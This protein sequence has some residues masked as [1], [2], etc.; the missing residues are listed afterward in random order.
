MT[1]TETLL[2]QKDA[3][4]AGK[5]Q[6]VKTGMRELVKIQLEG[7]LI[8]Q[9]A[10]KD[11]L[12]EELE[13]RGLIEEFVKRILNTM[14]EKDEKTKESSQAVDN[15]NIKLMSEMWEQAA[16]RFSSSSVN[17]F[18]AQGLK[19]AQSWLSKKFTTQGSKEHFTNSD[20]Y[21]FYES[22]LQLLFAVHAQL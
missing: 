11:T 17:K 4:V 6:E 14:K 7:H 20:L 21:K 3:E 5:L 1:Q 22:Q 16:E 8:K 18:K 19:D 10:N 13:V 12:S 15:E 9:F 2:K